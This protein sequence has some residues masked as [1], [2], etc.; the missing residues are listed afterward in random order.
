M[1]ITGRAKEII[2]RGGVKYHP[3]EVEEVVDRLPGVAACA[4]VP[5]SDPVLGERACIFVESAGGAAVTLDAVC[6]ALDAAGLA[7]F[8]WPERLERIDAMPLTPT[9][10][11]IRGRLRQRLD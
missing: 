2:N 5:Y 9:R 11:I 3:S 1:R 7:K 8:K 6:A 10:K 4:V